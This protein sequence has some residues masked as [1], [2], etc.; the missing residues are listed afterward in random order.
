MHVLQTFIC[1][2][3][4]IKDLLT[5]DHGDLEPSAHKQMGYFYGSLAI[6]FHNMVYQPNVF[7]RF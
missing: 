6:Q 3:W 4:E 5:M 7:F 2:A 1:E